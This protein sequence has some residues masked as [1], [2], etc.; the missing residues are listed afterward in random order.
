MLPDD[1]ITDLARFEQELQEFA[2]ALQLDLHAFQAD[3]ISLRCHQNTTAESW[4]TALLKAGTLLSENRINGRPICLFI[5]DKAILIGPWQ[6][7]C[8]E[9]PWPGEK[10]YPHE[11]WE[12]VELVLPG[13]AETLHQRALACLSDDALRTPGIKL[14]FSSPQ[15]EKERMPNP[16]LAITNGKVTIKFHPCDIRD[17]VASESSPL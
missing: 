7:T 5:L 4:K 3:H 17:V 11:G 15:G 8:I 14:K 13:D 1:L 12:H 10:Y 2:G 16:T 9:L 6:I